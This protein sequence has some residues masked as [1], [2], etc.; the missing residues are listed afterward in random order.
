MPMSSEKTQGQA[1]WRRAGAPLGYT[2]RMKR[3]MKT[4]RRHEQAS[5]W[6]PRQSTGRAARICKKQACNLRLHR[7]G[8]AQTL[9]Q[10]PS[11]QPCPSAAPWQVEL[12]KGGEAGQ[13]WSRVLSGR[14]QTLG[15]ACDTCWGRVR[16]MPPGYEQITWGTAR[17]RDGRGPVPLRGRDLLSYWRKDMRVGV[18]IALGVGSR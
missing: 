3:G 7:G 1:G 11:A 10:S 17:Y 18:V 15:V 13:R 6:V 4:T 14:G 8:G 9:Q 5:R 2:Q 16:K 12:Y